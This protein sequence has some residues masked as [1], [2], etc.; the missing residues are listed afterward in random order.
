MHA[1]PSTGVGPVREFL[2]IL[3]PCTLWCNNHPFNGV[4]HNTITDG[5]CSTGATIQKPETNLL[6]MHTQ[7]CFKSQQGGAIHIATTQHALGGSKNN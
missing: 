3:P 5:C 7:L 6:K 4:L 2:L 1:P